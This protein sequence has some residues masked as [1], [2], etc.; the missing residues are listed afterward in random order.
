MVTVAV[1]VFEDWR[2]IGRKLLA[3]GIPPDRVAWLDASSD[4]VP[5]PLANLEPE[6]DQN[7]LAVNA[8]TRVPRRFILLA[9][10]AAC[11]RALDKWQCL[12]RVLWR[13]HR[14]GP[15]VLDLDTDPEVQAVNDMA[16]APNPS[17]AASQ[18]DPRVPSLARSGAAPPSANDGRLSRLDGRP[19]SPRAAGAR[20]RATRT[21]D[22]R[23]VVGRPRCRHNPSVRG[24]AP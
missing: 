6:R 14:Q 3:R 15:H 2:R 20:D 9:D 11:H 17:D 1:R 21:R 8:R 19:R 22:R 16:Q 24:V 12:Y 13:I 5:P 18:R 4:Q 10:A 23:L 7:D